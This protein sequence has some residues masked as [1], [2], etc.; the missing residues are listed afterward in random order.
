MNSRSIDPLA[1]K[2]I[3]KMWNVKSPREWYDE[4]EGLTDNELQMIQ[5]RKG[6]EA[7]ITGLPPEGRPVLDFSHFKSV[8]KNLEN[9]YYKDKVT[10]EGEEIISF[11]R[12]LWSK[13]SP[14]S[15]FFKAVLGDH[16][17]IFHQ[18]R[19]LRQPKLIERSLRKLLEDLREFLSN[20]DVSWL[21]EVD[22]KLLKPRIEKL[23]TV[24]RIRGVG[25]SIF[26]PKTAQC[27]ERQQKGDEVC[28]DFSEVMSV[29]GDLKSMKKTKTEVEIEA[30]EEGEQSLLH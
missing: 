20:Y 7:V 15:S 29:L 6:I 25:L 28:L 13:D 24:K 16:L 10:P 19:M 11:F 21:S 30:D 17:F 2:V 14:E 3:D 5:V 22:L 8:T 27:E 12:D 9:G 18:A 26:N 1:N 23:K 4:I